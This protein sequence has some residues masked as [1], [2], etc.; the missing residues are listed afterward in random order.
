MKKLSVIALASVLIT[1]CVSQ[2]KSARNYYS[3]VD[4]KEIVYDH[5]RKCHQGVYSNKRCTYCD[6]KK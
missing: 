1:S 3:M 6:A 4:G 2:S 5:C